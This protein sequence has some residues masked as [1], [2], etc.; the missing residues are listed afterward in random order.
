MLKSEYGTQEF[1]VMEVELTYDIMD[2]RIR[3]N[4]YIYCK[5]NNAFTN[6]KIF[7]MR[8]NYLHNKDWMYHFVSHQGLHAYCE[9][10]GLVFSGHLSFKTAGIHRV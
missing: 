6:Y 5:H 10:V 4:F 1:N 2:L 9:C 8:W 7:G 3:D